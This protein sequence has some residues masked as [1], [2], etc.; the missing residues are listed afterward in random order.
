M[1]RHLFSLSVLWV[2]FFLFH[3]VSFAGEIQELERKLEYLKARQSLDLELEAIQNRIKQL[4]DE[5]QDVLE[6]TSAQ[7]ADRL[8]VSPKVENSQ[9]SS[10]ISPNET[11]DISKVQLQIGPQVTLLGARPGTD[12]TDARDDGHAN[13]ARCEAGGGTCER[14]G[15]GA[16]TQVA[17]RH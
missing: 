15:V 17:T 16:R 3:N 13:A 9:P 2:G 14:R 7:P 4:D 10:A 8:S 6:E 1:L 12:G 11:V 5:Y